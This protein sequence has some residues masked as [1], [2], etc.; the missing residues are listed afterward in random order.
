MGTARYAQASAGIQTAAL[1]SG[2]WTPSPNT[3]FANVEEYDGTSFTEVS[4]LGTARYGLSG[5]GIQTSAVVFG[6]ATPTN[7]NLTE[8]YTKA[9]TTRTID[10][11]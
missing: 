2:G 10:V 3:K 9:A 8:E 1:I 6:G 7:Q 5:D 4:N 11:S